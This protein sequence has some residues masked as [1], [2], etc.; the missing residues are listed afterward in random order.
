MTPLPEPAPADAADLDDIRAARMHAIKVVA[1]GIGALFALGA[2]AGAATAVFEDADPSVAGL[3]VVAA[4]A[5]AGIA[6][7]VWLARLLRRAPAGPEAASVKTARRMLIYSGGIGALTGI[8]IYAGQIGES[9][10]LEYDPFADTPLQ[11]GV[12][13]VLMA[14]LGTVVPWLT[15]R[16]HR[17]IDEHEAQAYSSAA[18]ITLYFYFFICSLWWLAFR[19]GFTAEPDGKIIFFATM[20]VWMVAWLWR[21]FR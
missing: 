17:N 19:G 13:L 20:A 8:M 18:L 3:L 15:L 11:P 7:L 6:A 14:L 21:K 5:G 10:P 9:G 1:A 4:F 16:W 2:T 12:A